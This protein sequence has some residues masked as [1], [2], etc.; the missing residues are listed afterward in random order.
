[1]CV[2]RFLRFVLCGGT[3]LVGVGMM[4]SEEI[5][6]LFNEEQKEREAKIIINLIKNKIQ[7]KTI[8]ESFGVE[9][10]Y[11]YQI[12]KKIILRGEYHG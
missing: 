3:I 4:M 12:A 2:E 10:K 5:Q 6:K 1:M 11:V 8:A 7:I 9:E